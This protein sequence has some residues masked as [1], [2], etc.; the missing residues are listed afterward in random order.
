MTPTLSF[1]SP[2]PDLNYLMTTPPRSLRLTC[3]LA[4]LAPLTLLA[5]GTRTG[6]KDADATAR[7]N[8]FAATADSAAAIYYNPAGLTQLSGQEFSASAYVVE[9]Q[10]E[11][12]GTVQMQRQDHVLPQ[13]YYAYAPPGKDYAFG[14]GGYVPFGLAT[15]WNPT[16]GFNTIATSAKETDYAIAA[17]GAYKL[18]PTL[19]IGGG[20]VF[21]RLSAT[22]SRDITPLG[23]VFTFDGSDYAVS[24][25]A[26]LRWQP[27]AQHAFGL[28]YQSNYSGNLTGT[29]SFTPSPPFPGVLPASARFTY[30]E[31]IIAG[32][33]YRPAP[34]WNVEADVE[35]MDWNRV[36]TIFINNAPL[37]AEALVLN[38][39]S[40]F[41]YDFGVTRTFSNGL[42][43]SAGYTY[44]ENSTPT[45]TYNPAVPDA[46]RQLVGLGAGGRLGGFDVQLTLQYGWAADR[47]VTGSP[48]STSLQSADGVYHNRTN[49]LALSFARHF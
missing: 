33:S 28:S 40:S 31:V 37:P 12:N 27:S 46:N 8:A 30:P 41:F 48:V 2:W 14:I 4:T 25:N 21:H 10:T 15:N 17:V 32:Y 3:L 16:S 18:S 39:R 43:V 6:F 1:N 11:Y 42:H 26:G 23:G 45:A 44:A 7:G 24:F 35:W 20:P 34:E 22:L 36:N 49:A 29:S 38:W 9:L 5:S 13:F 19:S 47:T